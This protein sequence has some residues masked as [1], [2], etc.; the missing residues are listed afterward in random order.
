M[1][2]VTR[3]LLLSVVIPAY[4]AQNYL[5]DA[6][7]S[8]LG[9]PCKEIEVL[10]VNDGS[11]DLTGQLADRLA[12]E[13]PRVLVIHTSNRGAAHARN[14]GIENA[15]GAYIAF[16]DA[17]DI[18][19]AHA[20]DQPVEHLLQDGNHDILSFG[21]FHADPMLHRGK[22]VPVAPGT[23]QN[24]D[25]EY[26]RAVSGKSFCSFLLRRTL[27]EGLRFP[28]GVRYH[29]DI[30]FLFLLARKSR[31]ILRLDRYLFLYRNHLSSAMHAM[32]DWQYILTD[33]IPA[34]CWARSQAT[35]EQ[36]RSDC[37]SMIYS[38]MWD[39]LQRS[40]LWGRSAAVLESEM[41]HCAPFQDVLTRLGTFWTQP[42]ATA[43][44]EAFSAAPERVCR[45]YRIL[46]LPLR[47]GRH[48]TRHPLL[49]NLYLRL[50]Y[51]TPINKYAN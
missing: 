50:K 35:C 44:L 49:R 45:K 28:E 21:Y 1:R 25:P 26:N 47:A 33:E 41:H 2:E 22:A 48:L 43:F 9:Q 6:V 30:T 16:L 51:R 19:C 40:A 3:I 14:L 29:E 23:L 38:L 5:M 37:D 42:E 34:W 4:N 11:T 10:I 13:D 46:G 24:G 27:L 7:R 18:W 32:T 31:N 12:R 39:Y 36:D 17:D 8:V 20:I 15:S